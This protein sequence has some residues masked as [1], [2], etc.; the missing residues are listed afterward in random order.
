VSAVD[1][2]ASG[3]RSLAPPVEFLC[4]PSGFR[5]EERRPAYRRRRPSGRR[6]Q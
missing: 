5:V 3:S 4:G 2:S 6:S 1:L